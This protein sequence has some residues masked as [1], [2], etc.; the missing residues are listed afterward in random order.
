VHLDHE[1]TVPVP[2]EQAWPVL[3]DVE[4]IGPCMPGATITKVEGKDFE[5]KVKVKVGPITVTY[6][7]QASFEDIDHDQHKAVIIAKGKEARGSGTA[8][9]TITAH[10]YDQGD[11]TRVTVHTDLAITGRPAQ[12][13]RGVMADVGGKLLGRFAECLSHQLAGE[14]TEPPA[15]AAAV[16]DIPPADTPV[17][18]TPAADTPVTDAAVEAAVTDPAVEAAVADAALVDAPAAEDAAAMAAATEG[19]ATDGTATDGSAADTGMAGGPEPAAA[20]PAAATA[21]PSATAGAASRPARPTASLPRQ[22]EAIDL[23]QTAGGPILKRL[24]PV[25]AAMVLLALLVAALRRRGR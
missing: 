3:L 5:G 15:A 4:R 8:N 12:F 10:L 23:L 17:T 20:A 2:A 7:G 21:P 11:S 13:G 22:D 25:L 19:A 18:D 9:A 6:A 24:A 1:F 16:A 14:D